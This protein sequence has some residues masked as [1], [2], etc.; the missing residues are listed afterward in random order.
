MNESAITVRYAK[1]FFSLAKEKNKLNELK[2]D[3]QKVSNIC[4]ASPDFILLLE[5]PVAKTSQKN[6]LFRKIFE[7]KID[8]LTLN[9]L[10][11]ILQNKREEYIP[12]ICRNFLNLVRKDQNIKSVLLTTA[13]EIEEA[14]LQNVKTLM[15]KELNANVELSSQVNKDLIGG[16]VLRFDDKQYDAS[17]VTKLKKIK[18]NFLGT[19]S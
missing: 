4:D 6:G 3:I 9:F 18:Q 1:A 13:S 16:L 2:A 8:S 5:S 12:D 7:G 19:K 14:S 17:V 15:E 10:L 11:L